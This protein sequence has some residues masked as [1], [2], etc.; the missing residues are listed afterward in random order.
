MEGWTNS[1]IRSAGMVLF[2]AFKNLRDIPGDAALFGICT[3]RVDEVKRRK[4]AASPF[5][6]EF[7]LM[8]LPVGRGR[9]FRV[10]ADYRDQ[11]H[12]CRSTCGYLAFIW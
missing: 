2:I 7:L 9:R 5:F 1:S 3:F 10:L 12:E 11:G 8:R 4:R 6:P